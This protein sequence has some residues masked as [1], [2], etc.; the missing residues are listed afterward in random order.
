M[1]AI[2]SLIGVP[3][4]ECNLNP[5]SVFTVRIRHSPKVSDC[6]C[7]PVKSAKEKTASLQGLRILGL[8]DLSRDDS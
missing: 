1:E 5:R 3:K 8:R 4:Q 7:G 6:L 2:S